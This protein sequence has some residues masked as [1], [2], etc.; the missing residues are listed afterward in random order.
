MQNP[1]TQAMSERSDKQL[2]DIVTLNR[3]DYQSAALEA[4]EAEL[5]K[6][7]L[8]VNDY[9][10]QEMIDE[11]KANAIEQTDQKQLTVLHKAAIVVAPALITF[12][13]TYLFN[14]MGQT[15]LTKLLALPFTILVLYGIYHNLKEHG[16]TKMAKEF[17]VW[18]NY[19]LAFYVVLTILSAISIYF[20]FS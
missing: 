12:L 2:V 17:V 7:N 4:A 18:C 6:R 19:T 1:F 14:T 8:D 11:L 9:Y 5:L 15:S 16:Y 20:F 3:E 10:T 13:V